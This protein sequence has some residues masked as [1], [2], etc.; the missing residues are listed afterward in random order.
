MKTP[1]PRHERRRSLEPS[2]EE[3]TFYSKE[4]EAYGEPVRTYHVRRLWDEEAGRW[5]YEV[6]IEVVAIQ[7]AEDVLGR[8]AR[9]RE[10]A[11]RLWDEI[12]KT[13]PRGD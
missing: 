11:P 1:E 4:Q 2:I 5:H 6:S 8:N 13:I 12:W 7:A 9:A 10:N 3:A